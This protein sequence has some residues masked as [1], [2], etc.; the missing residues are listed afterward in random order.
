MNDEGFNVIGRKSKT[1]GN[2][3]LLGF[4]LLIVLF[5]ISFC[6]LIKLSKNFE[7]IIWSIV[8][9][10][11][12]VLCLFSFINNYKLPNDLILINKTTLV[13]NEGGDRKSEIPL[14]EISGIEQKNA[15][16]RFASYSFGKIIISTYSMGVY[17]VKEL[18]DVDA[19]K[20]SILMA[21]P[22]KNA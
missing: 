14:A 20:T 22:R 3:S 16:A 12:A 21:L 15:R 13:I 1:S 19:V 9:L 4:F 5:I 10:P 7:Y 8:S 6:A 17:T 2:L 18:S 11:F